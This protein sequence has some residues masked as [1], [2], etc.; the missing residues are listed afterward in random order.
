MKRW[1][2]T[3][4]DLKREGTSQAIRA[5]QGGAC[6]GQKAKESGD[7][8]QEPVF[9]CIRKEQKRQGKKA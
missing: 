9:W 7:R 8:G 4:T 5:T 6:N 2:V 3:F 1:F